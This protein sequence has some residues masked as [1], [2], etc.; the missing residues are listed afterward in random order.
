MCKTHSA[1]KEKVAETD[2]QLNK[3]AFGDTIEK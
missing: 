3:F 1:L 2:E